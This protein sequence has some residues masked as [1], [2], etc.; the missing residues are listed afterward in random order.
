MGTSSEP[1]FGPENV[2]STFSGIGKENDYVTFCELAPLKNFRE[3]NTLK[4]P[5]FKKTDIN[6]K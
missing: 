1:P 6:P 5:Y 3:Q 4:I 2:T